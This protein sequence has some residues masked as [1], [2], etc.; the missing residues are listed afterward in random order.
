MTLIAVGAYLYV[1]RDIYFSKTNDT[2]INSQASVPNLR[3]YDV[4]YSFFQMIQD[5]Q[6]SEAVML[7]NP[8]ITKNESMKQSWGVQLNAFDNVKLLK[9]EASGQEE[10][11]EN[12]HTYMVT[13][14]ADMKPESANE[15]IPYFGYKTGDNIRWIALEKIDGKWYINGIASEP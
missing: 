5:D 8:K 12:R 4:I 7:M 6:I 3:D 11:R 1:N 14:D 2:T 10:W 15:E 9:V 13:F